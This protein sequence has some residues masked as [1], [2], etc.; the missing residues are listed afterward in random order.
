MG[1]TTAPIVDGLV[2][3]RLAQGAA[4]SDAVDCAGFVISGYSGFTY[5][6]L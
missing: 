5:R 3:Q 4:A 6:L 2:D 1:Y